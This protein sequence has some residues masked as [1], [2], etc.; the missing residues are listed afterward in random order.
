ML[1][2]AVKGGF[3]SRPRLPL[4]ASPATTPI[5]TATPRR[6]S[7]SAASPVSH[8]S[9]LLRLQSCRAIEEARRLHAALLV[10]GHR[11][12]TVLVAQLVH[13]YAK[14]GDVPQALRVFDGMPRRNSF[15]WNAVIKGLVDASRFSEALEMFWK[16]VRDGSVAA[17]GFTYPPVIKACAA[18]GA[19][20]QGRKVWEIVEADIAM[21]NARANVFVQCALVDMFAKCGCLDEARNVFE[22][23]Q[24]RD[25]ATWTA[26]IG[27]IVH[28]GDWLEVVDLFN[29]M[30]SEGFGVDSVIAA[31]VISACGKIGELWDGIALHGCAVKSGVSDVICVSNALVDMYCKCSCIEMA[32]CVFQSTNSKDVVSWSS[33]IAGYSQNGMHHVSVSLFCEMISSG[34][35]PNSSTL[36]SILPCLSEL[37][38]F[39]NGREIHC[40]S[41][42]HGLDKSEFIVSAL[43]DLYSN[44][45]LIRVAETIFRLMAV[46]DLAIWNSM[47]AGYAVNGYSD[48]A[49]CALRA[50]Q[51]VGLR[52]D[53]VTVVSVLPVCN[54]YPMLIQGKELHAYVVK[55]CVSSVCS[56][57][58]A[59]IDMYCKCGFLDIAKDV[60]QRMTERNTVTYNTMI[61]SFG[62]HSHEDEALLFFDLMKRDKI[63][64]DKVTFVA[65][66][67]C[68][69]HAGLVD[70][71]LHFYHSMLQ[72]YNIS[73]AKEHYSCIVDLYSRS[74]KLDEAWCFISNM[75]EDPEIDVLGGLL[76]AC[77]VHN[78]MDIAELVGKRIFDQNPQNPGYHILLSNIYADAGMWSDVERIRTVIQERSLK[79]E[80]GNSLT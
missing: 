8:A 37:K 68:C 32:D 77:R 69:S 48:S 51:K 16:T 38:L 71:G 58:N 45:G 13:A 34:I 2:F 36:A 80:T 5:S 66:I 53:H 44:Q 20:E 52:P 15:A 65:L 74:G 60:F 79:M 73:P 43:I 63:A 19:V 46:K 50:L 26:M 75:E 11:H 1:A 25:L 14:L 55:C 57:N 3:K 40:F 42:R 31:T 64:P 67:S 39:R 23:M 78:R 72:D 70:K 47:V 59:L 35:N 18:L 22:S 62:K 76:G 33:L 29:R 30:R 41:V 12:G 9:L 56:V 21:G 6:G 24:V 7:H 28:A 10:G 54:Q 4:L 49:F 61:S 17:D 27:G